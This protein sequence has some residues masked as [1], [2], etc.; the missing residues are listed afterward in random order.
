MKATFR[1]DAKMSNA[2]R[3]L[4]RAISIQAEGTGFTWEGRY[5]AVSCMPIVMRRRSIIISGVSCYSLDLLRLNSPAPTLFVLVHP[6]ED[7]HQAV[8]TLFLRFSY[9][10]FHLKVRRYHVRR[11]NN[12][13]SRI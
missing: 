7:V 12:I 9:L 10:Y 6:K 13:N 3:Q 4:R 1:H 8:G 5:R 2:W 11:L